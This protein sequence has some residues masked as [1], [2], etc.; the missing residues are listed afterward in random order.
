MTICPSTTATSRSPCQ[1]HG[2]RETSRLD[3]RYLPWRQYDEDQKKPAAPKA[4][5]WIKQ[6]SET[7]DSN[8]AAGQAKTLIAALWKSANGGDRLAFALLPRLRRAAP[9]WCSGW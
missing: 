1:M 6:F 7:I 4:I 5:S 8:D 9:T 3:A 2:L